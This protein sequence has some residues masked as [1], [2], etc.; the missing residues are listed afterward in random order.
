MSSR[1][2]AR[3]RPPQAGG[4][5]LAVDYG[6]RRIGLALSDELHLTAAPLTMLERT[7]RRDD[8]RRLREIVER[9]QVALILVGRPLHLDGAESAMSAEAARFAARLRKALRMPV[10]LV[11]ERLSS[12]AAEEFERERGSRHSRKSKKRDELAAAV[13]LRDYLAREQEAHA[14][15]R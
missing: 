9:H 12:W 2:S 15:R 14:P 7:N 1:E 10:E 3:A 8:L 13:I 5:I 6:R 11:D 4:R